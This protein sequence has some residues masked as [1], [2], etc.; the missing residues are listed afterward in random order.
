VVT[1]V[2][3]LP[4]VTL[5]MPVRNG[6]AMIRQALDSMIAQSY[7]NIEIIVSDNGSDDDTPAILRDY[8]G[9]YPQIR[10]IRQDPP[11]P[12]FDNFLYLLN[13]AEGEYFCWCAHDDTRSEDFV[14]AL[15]EAL[16][17]RNAVLAFGDLYVWNGNDT[18][19]IRADYRFEN[20]GFPMWRRV[21]EAAHN[22]CYHIYGLWRTQTLR[23]VKY[24]FTHWWPDLPIM[25][26]AAAAGDF[27]HVPDVKFFYYEILKTEEDR[28]QYQD[29][30]GATSRFYNFFS[31][32][33]A[34][35]VTVS[36]SAGLSAGLFAPLFTFEKYARIAIAR[37]AG[38]RTN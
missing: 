8:A 26:A 3:S 31:L 5:A 10:V 15:L 32:F 23:D 6:A 2:S 9:R 37:M 20:A 11:I 1:D 30:R 33:R 19:R 25:C 16:R 12:A 14:L 35:F 7:P 18:A 38:T 36:R 29:Y 27:I 22:Q 13:V 4:L 28:A 21:R 24:R 34:L 17:R